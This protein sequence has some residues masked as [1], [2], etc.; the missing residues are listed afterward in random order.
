[1]AASWN[2]VSLSELRGAYRMD[3]EFW[4]PEY[5]QAEAMLLQQPHDRLE[6]LTTTIRKGVFNILA[7]SYVEDGVAFY[8]SSN[9]GRI[10]PKENDLVFIT[11]KR[12]REENKTAL[13]RGDIML[14]KTGKE[15]ASVVLR[16]ECNVSQDVV[17]IRPNRKRIN[18]FYLA[19]FLNTRFGILQMRRWFQGQ[20]QAH[21]SL[22]DTRA[23]LVPLPAPRFQAV[24]EAKIQEI[25]QALRNATDYLQAAE[26]LLVTATG[27]ST[28]DSSESLWY[29]RRFS[30]MQSSK[31]FGAEYF[32]PC[33]SKIFRAL[34][35]GSSGPLSAYYH[36]VRN[37]FDP[38]RVAPGRMV[39]NFNLTDALDPVLDGYLPLSP[40]S[41][42]SSHKNTFRKDDVV[43]SRLRSYLREI[44]I[45]RT[46]VDAPA[47]GSTE[48]IV[49]RSAD[50]PKRKLT[51]EAL[52]IFLRSL[53]VQTILKW[54]QDGSQHP[55]F[56]EDDLLALPVPTALLNV[57]EQIGRLVNKGLSAR[58]RSIRL[59]DESTYAVEQAVINGAQ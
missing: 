12:H 11:P 41:E 43:I 23:I 4:Q 13:H 10:V 26:Q 49:L 15:A 52:F 46:P 48:F 18:P 8:R 51:P 30:E 53:P 40:A 57:S 55:R 33:K 45:V 25:E 32:M 59:M 14:A 2:T 50:H 6:E 20:V 29:T 44:A 34:K 7:D 36:S 16:D 19:A 28:V 24:I 22:P 56:N 37:L 35:A 47:I 17:A 1:M 31:R 39:R 21:L 27:L 54:S 42:I 58:D 38:K 9:V 5:L 3:A